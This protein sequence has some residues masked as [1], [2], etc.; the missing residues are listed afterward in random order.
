MNKPIKRL[1]I[2][3][4]AIELEDDGIIHSQLPLLKAEVTDPE[5]A[6]IVQALEAKNYSDAMRVITEWLQNQ[7][8]VVAWSDPQVSASKLE[9]KALEEQL[10]ELIDKRNARIQ[11]LDEFND[12]YMTRL[13][14]LMSQIL[15]LRKTLAEAAVRRQEAEARRREADYQRCQK[16]LSQAVNV[17]VMLTQ[18]WE[19]MPPHS[20]QAAEARKHLQQQNDLIASLL[21][22][23]LE[24]ESGLTRE[25]E[26]TRHARDEARQEYEN[27]QEQQHDAEKRFSFEQKMTEDERT[28]LKRLWRQASK[29]C[30]PDLVDNELKNEAHGMMVQLNQARE[31]GDLSAIR[32]L[33]TRLQQGL[34]PMMASDR[35]NDLQRLRQR[36]VEVKQHIATLIEELAALEKEETWQLVSTLGDQETYFRQQEKALTELRQTLEQQVSE[37]EYDEVA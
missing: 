8:S 29:L 33:L 15:N 13:G 30:H 16:Y 32:S 37:A 28:E 1:E 17:L 22:E 27:H 10:R 25:D 34:D 5:L 4:Y 2:I 20:I 6:F 11:L 7:R 36:I 19:S 12:L 26:P 24:L 18:R 23:A 3:K 9:L 14:P 35:L 31:R 21:A